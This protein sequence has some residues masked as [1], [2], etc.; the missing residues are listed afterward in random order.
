MS[1]T[2]VQRWPMPTCVET[3]ASIGCGAASMTGAA[4]GWLLGPSP[5]SLPPQA[6]AMTR[7]ASSVHF[8]TAYIGSQRIDVVLHVRLLG[9]VLP[10]PH[11]IPHAIWNV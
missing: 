4:S 11:A 6:E 1:A 8:D 2:G 9:Q 7:S 5:S 10:V 3:G